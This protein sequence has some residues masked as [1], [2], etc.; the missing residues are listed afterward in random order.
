VRS[1]G[2][3]LGLGDLRDGDA[4]FEYPVSP[5]CTKCGGRG[6]ASFT[7]LL[8]KLND[9]KFNGNVVA[10]EAKYRE[11][12]SQ[13]VG[14][15]LSP[16][17]GHN[18]ERVLQH[19]LRCC[20]GTSASLDQC[21]GPIY[22]MV[23]RTASACH[24]A[25]HGASAHV[26][27]LLFGSEHVGDYVEAVRTLANAFADVTRVRFAVVNVP[28]SEAIAFDDVKLDHQQRGPDALRE[29]LIAGKR[30]FDFGKPDLVFP[31]P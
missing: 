6:N 19:W 31:R 22:Q 28:T 23:H 1:V 17:P 16:S 7:D 24:V 5:R 12:L 18:K 30:L 29:A 25:S 15:W 3:L 13:T 26:V 21:T 27:H 8:L 11:K 14:K 20:I 4:W 10:V 9:N 2:Q